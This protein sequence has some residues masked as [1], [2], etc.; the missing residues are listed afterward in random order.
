MHQHADDVGQVVQLVLGKELVMQVEGPE[1]HV[2]DGHVVFVAAVER[3]VPDRNLRACGIQNSELVQPSGT[4]DVRQ[5]IVEELKIALA[6]KDH[7]RQTVWIFRSADHARHVLRNDV[8]QERGLAGPGHAEHDALHDADSVRPVPGLTVDV[9]SGKIT[10]PLRTSLRPALIG[11]FRTRSSTTGE[12]FSS[13]SVNTSPVFV[14][15][16]MKIRRSTTWPLA[17]VKGWTRK[18]RPSASISTSPS[19]RLGTS[20]VTGRPPVRSAIWLTTSCGKL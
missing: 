3:V 1:N 9:V 14:T 12:P 8:L 18:I 7:H 11:N 17:C 13:R 4:V 6:I 15:C 20:T 16:A 19:H 10:F 5:K 2:D